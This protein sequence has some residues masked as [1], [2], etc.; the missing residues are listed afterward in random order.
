[1]HPQGTEVGTEVAT[2]GLDTMWPSGLVAQSLELIS[3]GLQ[4]EYAPAILASTLVVRACMFPLGVKMTKNATKLYNLMP[5]TKKHVD[6][7]NK[8]KE[9]AGDPLP[10]T[11][12][13]FAQSFADPAVHASCIGLYW[14]YK[15]P[16]SP[17]M[18]SSVR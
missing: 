4:I 18:Q 10:L 5:E 16:P 6:K 17:S 14:A 2:A 15:L 3:S 7:M 9:E 12:Y 1:M 8:A 11:P 13:H